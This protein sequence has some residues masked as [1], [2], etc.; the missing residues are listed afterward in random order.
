VV[1]TA[2]VA[3]TTGNSQVAVIVGPAQTQRI[4]VF[5]SPLAIR[6]PLST[7]ATNVLVA[8][9]SP[10]SRVCYGLPCCLQ[11]V[12]YYGLSSRS[13]YTIAFRPSSVAHKQNHLEVEH[14][15]VARTEISNKTALIPG[16]SG[17][18][19]PAAWSV[20]SVVGSIFDSTLA[21]LGELVSLIFHCSTRFARQ[22]GH[23]HIHLL[24]LGSPTSGDR[25]SISG[26]KDSLSFGTEKFRCCIYLAPAPSS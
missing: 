20:S 17:E 3:I 6:N 5:Q 10:L 21:S 25:L 7:P 14:A 4:H 9:Q 22:C 8:L 2:L 18:A 11:Y 16:P 15:R 12:R 23:A 19:L 13:G 1:V 26:L 24:W